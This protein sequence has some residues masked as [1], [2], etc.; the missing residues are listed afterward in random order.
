MITKIDGESSKQYQA[1]M[2]FYNLGGGRSLSKLLEKY[3]SL[4]NPPTKSYN[5]LLKWRNKNDWETRI[6]TAIQEQQAVLDSLHQE[7]LLKNAERRYTIIDDMFATTELLELDVEQ[8]SV[9]QY[10]MLQKAILDAIGK[11]FN[12]DAPQKVALTD[13]SGKK[14]YMQ[15]DVAELLKLADAAK[16]RPE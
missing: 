3:R 4:E 9:A 6:I 16:R 11:T 14:P 1:L 2:D 10:V 5:T 12:L 13:P 7:E 8:V 15:E